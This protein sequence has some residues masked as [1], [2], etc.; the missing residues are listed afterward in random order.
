MYTYTLYIMPMLTRSFASRAKTQTQ[1]LVVKK[2][3]T[4]YEHDPDYVH[5]STSEDENELFSESDVYPEMESDTTETKPTKRIVKKNKKC[6]GQD[7]TCGNEEEIRVMKKTKKRKVIVD[8]EEENT[9]V[10]DGKEVN[11]VEEPISKKRFPVLTEPIPA[12]VEYNDV[13]EDDFDDFEE[14][15]YNGIDEVQ[16]E[17]LRK[18]KPEMYNT[19]TAVRE[20]L[21]SELPDIEK[22]LECP[23]ELKDRARVVELFEMFCVHTPLTHEWMELKQQIKDT[24]EKAVNKH[25]FKQT[26]Q[27]DIKTKIATELAELKDISSAEEETYEHTIALLKL[28]LKYKKIIYRKYLMVENAF[29]M[30]DE[31]SKAVEWMSVVTKIPFGTYLSIPGENVIFSLKEKLDREFY[32]MEHIKEQLLIYVS[33]KL[34]NPEIKSYPLGLIGPPGTA[35]TSIA[36]AISQALQFPFEQLS[37]GGLMHSDG[38]HGHSYTYIGS[39]CGDITKALIRM[40]CLNGILF[41]DEF[42]KLSTE[43]NLNSLLQLIDPVQ[44]H[45]FKDNYVGD[46]PIDLSRIWFI[47]SMNTMPE[48][49]ALRDRVYCVHLSGYSENDKFNILKHN[50]VPKLLTQ[51]QLHD[52]QIQDDVLYY[53]IRNTDGEGMRQCI[54]MMTNLLCK[55]VFMKRHPNIATTFQHIRMVDNQVHLDMVRE[56]MKH[57]HPNDTTYHS[58]YM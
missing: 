53:V 55:I 15:Y 4:N 52:I 13:E 43:K 10:V 3:S 1:P 6:V 26:L 12:E 14:D 28:P 35:K 17:I 24:M 44:N 33:N 58:M 25:Q 50:I 39:Q 19:L 16:M 54:H 46:I 21:I 5:E 2:K 51:H 56:L 49:Q 29:E 36:L 32:G 38:I 23:M 42:D 45:Q 8:D 41:I 31:V 37:G 34:Y 20:Y 27:E 22:I 7:D 48:N 30:N 11:V 57:Q 40:Q 47:L 9:S 18:N